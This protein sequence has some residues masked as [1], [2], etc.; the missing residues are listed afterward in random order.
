MN[1]SDIVVYHFEDT[2]L[3]LKFVSELSAD[4]LINL[5][6]QNPKICKRIFT[7]CRVNKKSLKIITVKNKLREM[8]LKEQ[9][10]R[11]ILGMSW[12]K[13]KRKM[14]VNML[15]L[16]PY[17][18]EYDDQAKWFSELGNIEDK[19]GFENLNKKAISALL[20]SNAEIEDIKIFIS[21]RAVDYKDQIK[22]KNEIDEI[23]NDCREQPIQFIEDI[24]NIIGNE[25]ESKNNDEESKEEIDKNIIEYQEELKNVNESYEKDK[26]KYETETAESIKNE[27]DVQ[28]EY[29]KYQRILKEKGH[30]LQTASLARKETEANK[31]KINEKY[32][33]EKNKLISEIESL[34]HERN[35][36]KDEIDKIEKDI[37]D[38]TELIKKIKSSI[39]E[40]QKQ[41][42]TKTLIKKGLK[43]GKDKTS[44]GEKTAGI[45]DKLN[46]INTVLGKV[47]PLIK[48]DKGFLTTPATLDILE[49]ISINDFN[50][51]E[52]IPTKLTPETETEDIINYYKYIA[53]W[54]TEKWDQKA[55][56]KY[57]FWKTVSLLEQKNELCAEI[58]L[59]G[60]YHASKLKSESDEN[61]L[62]YSFLC[63]VSSTKCAEAYEQVSEDE[64]LSIF[65]LAIEKAEKSPY[66]SAYFG[67]LAFAHPKIL[68]YLFDLASP[69][70]RVLLK[71]CLSREYDG[72]IE[73]DERDPTHEITHLINGTSEAYDNKIRAACGRWLMQDSIDTIAQNSRND[74]MALLA[75]FPNIGLAKAK[76]VLDDF[77]THVSTPLSK[78]VS[79]GQPDAFENLLNQCFIYSNKIIKDKNWM[80]SV[81]LFPCTIHLANLATEANMQAKR[82]F[83]AALT[84]NTDKQHYPLSLPDRDCPVEIVINNTG[85][86]E[87]RDMKLLVMPSQDYD[88][89]EVQENEPKFETLTP[90]KE[91][92]HV[93][94]IKLN[95]PIMALHLDY[96]L[97]WKDSSSMEERSQSG[98]LKLLSQR[99]VNWSEAQNPYSLKSIKDPERLKGR[100]DVL[101]VLR[102]SRLSMDSFYITGQRRTGKSSVAQVYYK[103]LN[104]V[105]KHAAIYLPWG[106]L[107]S[108]DLA[109]ICYGVCYEFA[110]KMNERTNENKL[111]CPE[112][113]KFK[114][115]ENFVF[116]TFFKE[117]HSQ[118]ANWK[119]FIIID[120]FDELPATLHQTEKGDQFFTLLRAFL[121]LDYLALYLVGSEKL[122]EILKRH[123]ERLNLTQR[124]EIDYIKDTNEINKI[125]TD[126]AVGI[127]EFQE[128]AVDEILRLSS[129]N[130]YYA[131]LICSRLFNV[132]AQNQD[133]YVSKRDVEHS[134]QIML[135]E[136]SLSTYQH[137]WKDGVFLPGKLGDSQ[138]YHNA[139]VL[140]S[141]ARAETAEEKPVKKGDL[142]EREDLDPINKDDA[143]YAISGL[144]DRKVII[145]KEEGYSIR[146]PL[147]ARWISKNGASAVERSFAEAGLDE[148]PLKITKLSTND[149]IEISQDLVFKDKEVNEILI[150]NW[151]S[152]FGNKT[153]QM[154]AY[155]LLKRLRE[156]GYFNES[157]KLK[158]FKELHKEIIVNEAN[159][160]DFAPRTEKRSVMNMIISYLDQTGKSGHACE[161]A[162]RRINNIHSRCAMSPEK[163]PNHIKKAK[164]K[165]PIIFTDD[166]VGTGGTIAKGFKL[167][168]ENMKNEGLDV[169]DYNVYLAT[170]TATKTGIDFVNNETEGDIKILAWKVI[171]E[172]LKAFDTNAGIFKDNDER[173][174]AKEMVKEIGKELEK[175]HPLGRNDGQLLIAFQHGCPN[176]T[177]PIFYKSGRTYRG[178]EWRPIFP[179]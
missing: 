139:K 135:D 2:D 134:T 40:K 152:Q 46:K 22:L 101:D 52:T 50:P 140:I 109:P 94:N 167:F 49:Q 84:I 178:K 6:K 62:L 53:F 161:Y 164:H 131:T 142:I 57:S 121:D 123:G 108:T 119:L 151:L 174:S 136:D 35:S 30:E 165:T 102:R 15:S 85:N 122:P 37:I 88:D 9:E 59:A 176:N 76:N 107:G 132:M 7:G 19:I 97:S 26:D 93:V 4:T 86:T 96:I 98:T 23:I 104:E 173:Q 128:A 72:F 144:I 126:P 125:I 87:A 63:A 133:Y 39:K 41:H 175:G 56:V 48:N 159:I 169:T 65:E 1:S 55:I 111:K 31:N 162:Y 117:L 118:Y 147:F 157:T 36:V 73:I 158:A 60:L 81:Y 114:D 16:M 13:S 70:L 34:E 160:G 141:L 33:Y 25:K 168:S 177:L 89:T 145:E 18:I 138:Q 42:K 120:D 17:D 38:K 166:I 115:N 148:V 113:S 129:G 71:R 106:D 79:S 28:K 24:E 105:E 172:K 127:L 29:D 45:K 90:N 95:S 14:F 92:R 66:V 75:R 179:R 51:P 44:T 8:A 69:R 91:I 58:A 47:E 143:E 10:V 124:C 83:K 130:P 61:I 68:D 149:I 21:L 5:L 155:K 171:D 80:T 150:A 110:R 32:E 27:E 11:N 20:Y 78:A 12:L 67:Q 43:T 153:N 82:L 146:V 100:S 112:I 74:L 137:F 154:I 99:K 116:R 103:E 3:Y 54:S 77:E 64:V 163:I 156:G 170:I